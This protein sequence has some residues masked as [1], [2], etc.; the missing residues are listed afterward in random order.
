MLEQEQVNSIF[1]EYKA[2]QYWIE[3]NCDDAMQYYNKKNLLT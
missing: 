3:D 2:I 1:A